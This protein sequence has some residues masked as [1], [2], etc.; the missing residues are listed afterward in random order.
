M[1]VTMTWKVF[2]E[3]KPKHEQDIIWLRVRGDYGFFG[4][5]PREVTVEYQWEEID[6]EGYLTGVGII[7][8]EGDNPP[9]NCQLLVLAEGF[10][11]Q[12]T[13][14]WMAVEE[15]DRFLIENIPQ[16]KGAIR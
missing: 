11:I 12:E 5:E 13:D 3:E 2:G 4:F 6:D 7:Y 9:E 10:E 16:L 15:Y 8:T 1:S 14:L